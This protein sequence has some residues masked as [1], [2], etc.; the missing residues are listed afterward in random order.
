MIAQIALIPTLIATHA[1]VAIAQGI[2]NVASGGGRR[3]VARQV[4]RIRFTPQATVDR[5]VAAYRAE[6]T[7]CSLLEAENRE[8]KEE[9]AAARRIVKRVHPNLNV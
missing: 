4:R 2:A 3:P 5:L 6:Q 1:A 9:L 7:R 8:L